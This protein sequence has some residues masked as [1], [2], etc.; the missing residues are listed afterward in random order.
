MRHSIN[1][2][3]HLTEVF[4]NSI[5]QTLPEYCLPQKSNLEPNIT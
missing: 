1:Q 5:W 4:E 2:T 3:P